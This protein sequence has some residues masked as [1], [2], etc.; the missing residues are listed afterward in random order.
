[1]VTGVPGDGYQ[2]V[3]R[4]DQAMTDVAVWADRTIAGG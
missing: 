4:D 3:R 2:G 1:M